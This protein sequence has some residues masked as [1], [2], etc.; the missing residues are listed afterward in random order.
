MIIAAVAAL[1]ALSACTKTETVAP[2]NSEISFQTASYLT[3][4]T[5]TE[6]P[7][8]ETFGVFAWTAN[9]AGPY[10][11]NDETVSYVTSE[12]LWKPSTTYYWPKGQSVDFVSYYPAHMSG[13]TVGEQQIDYTGI[14]VD[15]LQQDIMY[16]DKA[17]GFSDNADEVDDSVNG[18]TGV[19]AFFRHAL[20]KVRVEVILGYNY[21]KEDDGTETSWTATLDNFNLNGIFT[22]GDCR[23]VLSDPAATGVV[24]W[25]KPADANGY[26]VWTPDGTEITPSE[27]IASP[28]ALNTTTPVVAVQ[29]FFVLPQSLTAGQQTFNLRVSVSTERNGAPFLNESGIPLSGNFYMT[30]LEAWEM[31]HIYIYRIIINPLAGGDGTTDPSDPDLTDTVITFDPAIDNWEIVNVA[32]SIVL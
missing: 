10:F 27:Q 29:E 17:A 25:T 21:K 19:P 20:A 15:A 16:A 8:T 26:N 31:N 3:R 11:M 6:F 9:T 18:Y 32:T 14:N 2:R 24:P 7:K 22:T 4:V 30:G 13:I 28:L 5:G 23:L 12:D 1:V